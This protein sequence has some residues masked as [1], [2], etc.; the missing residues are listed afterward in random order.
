MLSEIRDAILCQLTSLTSYTTPGMRLGKQNTWSLSSRSYDTDPEKSFSPF[1]SFSSIN[2]HLLF[3]NTTVARQSKGT[4]GH[5][6]TEKP[7]RFTREPVGT[8][9]TPG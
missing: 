8:S 5:Q 3:P 4:R 9:C 7:S 2:P 6:L 1:C